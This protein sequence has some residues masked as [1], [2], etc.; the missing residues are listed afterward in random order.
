MPI[1]SHCPACG[2]QLA[3]K[4]PGEKIDRKAVLQIYDGLPEK[5]VDIL[6]FLSRFI[7]ASQQQL[8]DTFFTASNP[9]DRK[10]SC[11]KHL[12]SLLNKGLVERHAGGPRLN[13]RVFHSLSPAGMFACEVEVHGDTR[14]VKRLRDVKA[15]SLLSSVH[16]A[17][18]LATVDVMSSFVRAE[19]EGR[20]ELLL[21]AGDKQITYNF[22][23]LGSRRKIQPDSTLLWSANNTAYNCW[24]EIENKPNCSEQFVEKVMKYCW[25]ES[26]GDQQGDTYRRTLGVNSFPPLLV[27]AVRRGQLPGLRQAAVRGVLEAHVGTIPKVAERVVIAL[28]ALDDIR[29]VGALGPCWE[30]PLQ[31]TGRHHSYLDLYSFLA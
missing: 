15:H 12:A 6:F 28:A 2:Y 9:R 20:G 8:A 3:S 14:S 24:L 25:F 26:A 30:I 18:H 27:V 7:V 10:I 31:A 23:H 17:H 22:L 19:R 29:E 13:G 4:I 16:V 1:L 5:Q 21:Y 11:S